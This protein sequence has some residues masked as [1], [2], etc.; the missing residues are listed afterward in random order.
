MIQMKQGSSD[1]MEDVIKVMRLLADPTRMRVLTMLQEREMNVSALCDQLDLAQPTVSH[2]LGLLR[3]MNLVST[4]RNGKQVF[5]SLNGAYVVSLDECGGL[6]I[7]AGSKR[8]KIM[9]NRIPA[10][11]Q[12][13]P[14]REAG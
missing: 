14:I 3:A 8:L 4:R 9:E 2:H 6:S 11:S 13:E 10:G 12:S 1:G 5:Y 7:V